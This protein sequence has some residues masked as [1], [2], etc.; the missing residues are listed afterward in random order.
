MFAMLT[1]AAIGV[2]LAGLMA[3]ILRLFGGAAS[4]PQTGGWREIDPIELNRT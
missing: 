4:P 3:L 2:V 1:R